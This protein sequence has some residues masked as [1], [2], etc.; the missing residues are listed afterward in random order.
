MAN[1]AVVA[2]NTA[3]GARLRLVPARL[4]RATILSALVFVISGCGAPR[5]STIHLRL[6]G[7][8][9]ATELVNSWL[10]A[11]ESPTF[12][13]DYMQPLYLSQ[14]G[15]Q[16]L[17]DGSADLACT[18][19]VITAREVAEL[20]KPVRG[21]RIGFYG[22]AFYVN[23]E[24]T[25]D[26]LFAGH[27]RLLF[28]KQ[29]RDWKELGGE[30]DAPV[31]LIG[32]EKGTRGGMILMQQAGILLADATWETRKSDAEVIADVATDTAALGFAA[33]GLD[34]DV[35]YVGLRTERNSPPAFPSLEEIE[36]ERY[37]LAKVI[38]VYCADPV[39]PPCQA[40]LDY[41]F[42]DAGHAAIE[43]TRVWPLPRERSAA[44]KP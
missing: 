7:A 26:S 5:Y 27:I 22:Y 32:P 17:R 4:L 10:V 36:S 33:I 34:Q 6:A 39:P 23:R 3:H 12:K 14:H 29:I 19:R 28:R 31:R 44:P 20:G 25:I 30:M 11:S 38:Y 43:S 1:G 2:I 15:F 35:R 13:T 37:G 40:A 42:S 21:F 24:N 41:L 9:I 8:Q 16:H 18:D